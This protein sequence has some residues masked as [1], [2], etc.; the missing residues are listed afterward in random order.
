MALNND[1]VK[2]LGEPVSGGGLSHRQRQQRFKLD[3]L[4][5]RRWSIIGA[6][7]RARLAWLWFWSVT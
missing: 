5:G 7:N 2:S 3:R 6:G 1:R 4:T